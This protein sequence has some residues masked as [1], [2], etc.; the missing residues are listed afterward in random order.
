MKYYKLTDDK[1]RTRNGTQW[2]EGVTHKACGKGNQLCTED[3]IHVY[4]HPLKAAM[5]NPVHASFKKPLLWECR[6]RG[7]VA[8]DG[9]K[10]G[11]KECTTLRQIPLPKIPVAAR[12]R[13][14]ILCALKV[15]QEP[16]FVKW[17]K[18]WLANK[19]RTEE[20]AEKKAAEWSAVAVAWEPAA[21]A[22]AAAWAAGLALW[23]A[24][25]AA[26]WAVA[27]VAVVGRGGVKIDIVPLIKRAITAEAKIRGAKN[28]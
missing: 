11:V 9:L 19:D 15:Y 22:R 8:N 24:A 14:A 5:F 28:A 2:G 10:V 6:V 21:A 18:D 16:A 20:A 12:V 17:A 1:G 25:A 13:V 4:D 26:A 7:V 3:V 23:P 27:A